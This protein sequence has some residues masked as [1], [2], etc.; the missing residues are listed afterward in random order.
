MKMAGKEADVQVTP[1]QSNMA[2]ILFTQG[3]VNAINALRGKSN[4]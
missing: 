1:E 2:R 4:E 3:G